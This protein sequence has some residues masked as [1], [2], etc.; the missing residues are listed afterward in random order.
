MEVYDTDRNNWKV[1]NYIN[2]QDKLRVVY[3]GSF[4]STGKRIIIFGGLKP[5]DSDHI[6]DKPVTVKDGSKEVIISNESLYLN[7]STGEINRGTDLG[8]PSYYLSGG[9]VF[10]QNGSIH[11]FGFTTVK[12]VPLF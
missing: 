7:V 6:S 11:A 9:S 2:E 12:E 8:R 1:I 5:L 3:P 4:Q 10:P